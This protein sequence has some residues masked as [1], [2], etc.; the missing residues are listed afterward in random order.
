MNYYNIM[1]IIFGLLF[2]LVI[3]FMRAKF[4]WWPFH[5]I[6]FVICSDWGM[7]YLWSCMLVS[8]IVKWAVLKTGGQKASQQLIMFA[9]GLMLGDFT[10]GG[11]WSLTSVFAR[12]PMYNFCP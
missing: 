8:S 11:L 2:S 10:I 6:G 3:A 5:P 1:G 7:R 4:I 12:T 9:I